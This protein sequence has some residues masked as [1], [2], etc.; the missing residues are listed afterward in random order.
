MKRIALVACLSIA[1]GFAHAASSQKLW[2]EA[3]G[4]V[5]E[6]MA[7]DFVNTEFRAEHY[8]NGHQQDIARKVEALLKTD[9]PLRRCVIRRCM[10]RGA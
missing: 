7:K 10:E 3:A 6:E 1:A 4:D 5:A 2:C 9:E 8:R